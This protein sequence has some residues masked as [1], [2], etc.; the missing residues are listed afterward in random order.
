MSLPRFSVRNPIL[1]NLLMC[2]I[3][4][5]GSLCALTMTREMFPES[6]PEKLPQRHG[7]LRR[8]GSKTTIVPA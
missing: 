1:V 3:L 4:F 7:G 5:S 2:V 8:G 6:R